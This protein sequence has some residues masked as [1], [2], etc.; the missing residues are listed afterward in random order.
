[1]ALDSVV[2]IFAGAT[3]DNGDLTIPAGSITSWTP[4][5]LTSPGG[6]E[7]VYSLLETLNAKVGGSYTNLSS[8]ATSTIVG[9]KLR[10]RYT[11]TVD[12]DLS[13]TIVSDLNVVP[14]PTVAPAP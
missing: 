11:F 2:D 12:L 8:S 6:Y 10:R 5:S 4:S 13:N 14:E 3:V 9:T 7:L 1:M